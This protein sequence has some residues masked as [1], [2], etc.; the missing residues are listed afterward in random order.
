MKNFDLRRI[1]QAFLL[2]AVLAAPFFTVQAQSSTQ[3]NPNGL[4][5]FTYWDQRRTL[6][7]GLGLGTTDIV[8]LGD[9]FMDR[10]MWAESYGNPY[11]KNRGIDADN[12]A[13][14]A[15]RLDDIIKYRPAKVFIHIGKR[16]IKAGMSPELAASYLSDI[17]GRIRSGSKH[18]RVYVLGIIPDKTTPDSTLAKYRKYD[19]IVSE[20]VP[21]ITF[22]DILPAMTGSDGRLRPEFAYGNSV[23]LN[24]KGYK[25]AVEALHTYLSKSILDDKGVRDDYPLTGFVKTR[26][27]IIEYQPATS[28]D[29][30]MIGNSITNGGEWAELLRNKNAK[31][32][33]ISSDVTDGVL[34]RLP[35]M[36]RVP[37]RKVFIMIGVND[38]GNPPGK[39][40]EY[41]VENIFRIVAEI[42]RMAP[43]TQIYVQSLL[44][45][46]PTF[47]SFRSH[48]VLGEPIRRINKSLS[49]AAHERGYSF[50]DLHGA[51]SDRDGNLD[52]KYTNDG[53][54]L[55]WEGYR[56]WRDILMS[57][58]K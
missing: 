15:Y 5:Y 38:L 35:R 45:V 25:A 36:L 12:L 43:K 23:L 6:F 8:M 32:R 19:S 26:N 33:G 44:P 29:I 7:A 10:G 50:I 40:E 48:T 14:L 27:S 21:G 30:L 11:I 13:G 53:L 18:T 17:V 52:A 46:N 51:M 54:H 2:S 28:D 16:D 42:K 39:T 9:D 47:P 49:A 55:C 34:V 24:G 57:Y 58:M 56:L 41:V 1:F 31:N 20:T 37:P 4:S 3:H 22:V